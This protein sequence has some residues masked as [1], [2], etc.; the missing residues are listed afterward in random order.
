MITRWTRDQS[1]RTVHGNQT[2]HSSKSDEQI[3]TGSEMCMF[4]LSVSIVES[5]ETL[6]RHWLICMDR[7]N[8][9][10]ELHQFDKTK[11]FGMRFLDSAD[12]GGY[13]KWT[14]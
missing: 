3:A 9:M 5:E 13:D 11:R 8:A 10:H 2:M 12:L 4:A 1:I 14:A 6:R 7:S